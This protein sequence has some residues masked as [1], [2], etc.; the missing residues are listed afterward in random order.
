M[1]EHIITITSDDGFIFDAFYAPAYGEKIGSVIII[2]EIFGLTEQLKAVAWQ[3]AE[4]GYDA[5]VPALFDRHAPNTVIPFSTP[6]IGREIAWALDPDKV[7]MDIDATRNHVAGG[8][9][10]SLVGFCWGGGQA[11]RLAC[12]TSLAPFTS[13]TAY[14]GTALEKHLAANPQ[15]PACPMLFHFGDTDDHTP[16]EVIKAVADALPDA[17]ICIFNAGHAFANDHRETYVAEAAQQA[18]Q[19]TLTFLEQHHSGIKR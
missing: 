8:M 5:I 1:S 15:G 9:G 7:A 18:W 12:D 6:L 16:K 3:Y 2:Q 11:F 13:A 14:Y 19:T 4:Q 17:T 10:V